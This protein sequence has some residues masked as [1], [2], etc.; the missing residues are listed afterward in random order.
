MHYPR[1]IALIPDGNRT[2]A[3][4]RW[5][6]SFIGHQQGFQQAK[7]LAHYCMTQTPIE[8]ITIWGASTE[9]IKERSQQELSYL[10]EIYQTL[11]ND[12]IELYEQHGIGFQW[13]GS[14]EGLPTEL[15]QYF[16][17]QSKRYTSK[18]GKYIILAVN[19]GG[20]DEILRAIQT[21]ITT[22]PGQVPNL[23][24]IQSHL[25]LAPFPPVELVIRT[26]GKIAKRLSGFM[27]WRIGYAELYFSDLYFPDFDSTQLQT[28]L[29]RFDSVVQH[30]NYGK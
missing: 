24:E 30:R 26:K 25:D 10:Y 13:I 23:W 2:R 5:L 21:Y 4:E 16:R 12:M 17:D 9:N 28:A 29:T 8:V 7:I 22:H 1:H 11:T 27:T 3:K 15:V 6:P 20:Q 14:E 18:N 19:Y